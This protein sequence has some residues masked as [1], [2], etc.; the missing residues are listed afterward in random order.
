MHQDLKFTSEYIKKLL[1]DEH[2]V[3]FYIYKGSFSY[4][5]INAH[6]IELKESLS[7]H[8]EDKLQLKKAYKILVECFENINRHA[9][10]SPLDVDAKRPLGFVIVGNHHDQIKICLGNFILNQ[11]VEAQNDRMN[12]INNLS[13]VEL[14]E[15]YRSHIN[16]TGISD[17]GGAGLGFM[18][19]VLKSGNKLKFN[20]IN[21]NESKS[22]FTLTIT[23]NKKDGSTN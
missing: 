23:I 20:I 9:L 15:Y 2:F 8:V 18:D 21:F 13:E 17:K 5:A 4:P 7:L 3:P 16:N 10:A 22:L 14:K 1:G 6:L 19:M 12:K 11:L